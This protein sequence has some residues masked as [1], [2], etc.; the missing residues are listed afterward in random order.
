MGTEVRASVTVTF[1]EFARCSLL[2]LIVALL[3]LLIWPTTE[4]LYFA[5]AWIAVGAAAGTMF[6]GA[7]GRR[8][9]RGLRVEGQATREADTRSVGVVLAALV[10]L[11]VLFLLAMYARSNLMPE[12]FEWMGIGAVVFVLVALG[13]LSAARAWVLRDFETTIGHRVRMSRIG[14]M[15]VYRI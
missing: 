3:L 12:Q 11:L 7:D 10:P 4:L 2:L 15:A 8:I 6:G 1:R 9:V 14:R 5:F 13:V